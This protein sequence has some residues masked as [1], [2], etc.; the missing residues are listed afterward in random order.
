[1]ININL[2][3][4]NN[5]RITFIDKSI[6]FLMKIKEAN[7]DKIMLSVYITTRYQFWDEISKKLEK[8]GIINRI[9]EVKNGPNNY[10]N[11]IKKCIEIDCTYS[12]SMDDDV[13]I[14][15][16]LW[17]FI[18]ENIEILDDESNLFLAPLISNGIPSVDL[19]IEDF[20]DESENN[21][22]KDIFKSTYIDNMWG[23]DYSELN[24]NRM[25]WSQEFYQDVTNINHFYKGIHP[26]RVSLHAH[27]KMAEI[28]CNK[29]DK[30]ISDNNFKIEKYKFPYF[31]NSFYFIKT[32]NWRRIINDNTLFRDPYDEVPLNLYME[33]NNL[34]ML[35]IRNG[36]CL[37]MAYN[38]IGTNNQKNIEKYYI[39][40]FIKK[41]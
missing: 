15:N 22:M 6:D 20:C 31:C 33:K 29:K 14:S 26:M 36:F 27:Q 7:K 10:L 17:D 35:F 9:I 13:L 37:H 18:I 38:T 19:F 1:M 3:S 32:E 39:E 4:H 41:I 24:K 40:N 12:C 23:V 16:Y 5:D 11:K 8:N 2:L 21:I 25:E 30:F 28:I 34:N